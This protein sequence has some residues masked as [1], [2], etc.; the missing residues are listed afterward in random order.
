MAKV[1]F[2]T[3]TSVASRTSNKR[4]ILQVCY[5]QVIPSYFQIDGTAT[6]TVPMKQLKDVQPYM[7]RSYFVFDA[8]VTESLTRSKMSAEEELQF[9]ERPIKIEFPRALPDTFK[10]GMDYKAVVRFN[11]NYMI[12][13]N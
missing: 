8:N 5:T 1:N 7:D 11:D 4:H 9:F 13:C 3:K 12:I 10:P 6:F 2:N